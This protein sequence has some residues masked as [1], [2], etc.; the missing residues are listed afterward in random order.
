MR[1]CRAARSGQQP[2]LGQRP[3]RKG[4]GPGVQLLDEPPLARQLLQSE[5][6]PTAGTGGTAN[7]QHATDVFLGCESKPDVSPLSPIW[8]ECELAWGSSSRK[9]LWDAPVAQPHRSV[10]RLLRTWALVTIHR[11]V[12]RCRGVPDRKCN[13]KPFGFP[14]DQAAFFVHRSRLCSDACVIRF[15][16]LGSSCAFCLS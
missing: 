6:W 8:A 15:G 4:A 10:W 7:G 14:W 12:R 3:T 9:L 5:L 2:S 16:G 11:P 1:C 13:A